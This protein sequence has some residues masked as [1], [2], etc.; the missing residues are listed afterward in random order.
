MPTPGE[1]SHS[2]L[3][4]TDPGSRLEDLHVPS[5]PI[6]FAGVSRILRSLLRSHTNLRLRTK[7]LLSLVL[8]TAALTSSTL[9][10]VRHSAQSQAQRQIEQDARN[11]FLTI[12]AVQHQREMMLSH[13][14]D[15]LATLAY[16][17]DGDATTVQ[18]A[19]Q[20]PWQ[21]GDCDLFALADR[22]GRIIAL[23]TTSSRLSV[24]DAEKLFRGSLKNDSSG[25]WWFAGR[26]LFQVVL[27]PYYEDEP[28]KGR[29]LGTV[30]VGRELDARGA[31]DLG[32][33]SSSHLIFRNGNDLVMSTF[34]AAKEEELER[35]LRGN[36]TG[37]NI[38][39]GE[40]RFFA[41]SLALA[42][43]TQPALRLTVLK[44]YDEATASL[45]RLNHLLVGL[46]LAAV[47]GGGLLVFVI[48]DRSTRPLAY[49]AE[50]VRA[51]EQGDFTYPL[52]SDGGDEVAQVTRAFEEMRSTLQ[53]NEVQRQQH[54]IQRQQH[55]IQRQQL[56]GQRQQLEGQLRQAQ[57]MDA[58]GRL[59]GGVAHDFN[60]LL[61]V[62]KGNSSLLVERMQSD[63]RLLGCTRQ[64][65]SAADRAAG[66]TR[67]L[68][69]FCRM[70]VLQP[71]ILDLNMLVS[72][73]CKLL[74]R[75]IR[76]DIAF[77]FHAG[78]SL[79]RVKADPGQ[80][81]QVIMNL[82]VNAGD[83][84]PAGGSLTIETRNI[85]VDE[86]FARVRP[87]ILPGRYVLIAV[88]D[89]GQ[90]MNAETKARIFEPF[91]TTKEQGKGTGLGLA[92]VY[93]IVKQSGGCV[94]VESEPEKGARF[95]VY[96][97][98]VDEALEPAASEEIVDTPTGRYKTVLIAEDEEAVRELASGFIASAGYTVLTA[99]DG[100]EALALAEQSEEP[101]HLLLT[102]V[103]MPKMRGPELAKRLK[104]L[105]KTIR[106]VY[107][108]GYLE[109]N[110]GNEDF[111]DEGFFLQ[112]PFS[113]D[114]L[115]RKVG[116]A[117]RNHAPAKSVKHSIPN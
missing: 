92:T 77:T 3:L 95:E 56:E 4:E 69:A 43:G 22:K 9:L 46:G 57:K 30:I 21:S 39:I 50:G 51:L 112:K 55:E 78:E 12:Q 80:I 108:S 37:Q 6:H 98:R 62:I 83:A 10:V 82:A 59:A 111:L 66:L 88:T 28:R 58:M 84:M 44:S 87:P 48:S 42:S 91:F 73:M 25:G 49:L 54:E 76:E 65:E 81:E 23:H 13:K 115:V 60:N 110:P 15:L 2:A 1:L 90:G 89:T 5:Q 47:L 35:Q 63:D 102:D 16:L 75:L 103:V 24:A 99:K 53:R 18:D 85:T 27:Q 116:E 34:A 41:S 7:L 109:Y 114:T 64:I 113:R 11:A 52:K 105:R 19:S 72:E 97:P 104:G 67:Q 79:G 8:S 68:L 33:I 86:Q 61:T 36:P 100:V 29:L 106:I 117:L 107:M 93:G 14:A 38:Q 71:K 26:H 101:I 31:S 96:L 40:Q 32:R 94:W 74:R 70:Q 45:K 20:D 17:R